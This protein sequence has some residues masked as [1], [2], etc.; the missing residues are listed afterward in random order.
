MKGPLVPRGK[1]SRAAYRAVE[2]IPQASRVCA[3]LGARPHGDVAHEDRDVLPAGKRSKEGTLESDTNPRAFP[4]MWE[5]PRNGEN[6]E[7][8]M[9]RALKKCDFAR[10]ETTRPIPFQHR[11]IRTDKASS[12]RL[13]PQSHMP[14]PSS[15][16][17]CDATHPMVSSFMRRCPCL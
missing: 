16:Y 8:T 1:T 6:L 2:T 4:W 14:V 7:V 9:L 10:L 13:C 3:L 15:Q 5:V 17:S 12:K 11:S